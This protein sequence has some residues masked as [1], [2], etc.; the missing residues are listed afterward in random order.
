MFET[1]LLPS[2]FHMFW[3]T[4]LVRLPALILNQS[5]SKRPCTTSRSFSSGTISLHPSRRRHCTSQALSVCHFLPKTTIIG[6]PIKSAS[7]NFQP[8]SFLRSSSMAS[9]QGLLPSSPLLWTRRSY[10][11]AASASRPFVGM[12]TASNG[13][14]ARGQLRPLPS[15]KFSAMAAIM[16]ETPMPWQPIWRNEMEAPFEVGFPERPGGWTAEAMM[17]VVD[18]RVGS[19]TKV[20]CRGS[21]YRVPKWKVWPSSMALWTLRVPLLHFTH[22]SP[23]WGLMRSTGGNFRF[24]LDDFT[25]GPLETT[26]FFA[27]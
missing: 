5:L 19:E 10:I 12:M 15:H 2:L 4:H 13:A 18:C 1:S 7:V 16:R 3:Y 27:S 26:W 20:A 17:S 24:L 11:A 23:S 8:S 22:L 25:C 9:I 6:Y 14:I 21:L